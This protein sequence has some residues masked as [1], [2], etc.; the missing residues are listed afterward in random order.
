[1]DD[2]LSKPVSRG[3]LKELVSIWTKRRSMAGLILTKEQHKAKSEHP[4]VR[5]VVE[6]GPGVL[7]ADQQAAPELGESC[8]V[9]GAQAA[10][11]PISDRFLNILG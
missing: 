4:S 11:T 6:E 8:I 10:L 7:M 5:P 1:M 9:V 2:Y 3:H